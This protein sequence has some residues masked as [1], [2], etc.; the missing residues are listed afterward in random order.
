M[1]VQFDDGKEGTVTFSSNISPENLTAGSETAVQACHHH[2]PDL[3]IRKVL[4]VSFE[5]VSLTPETYGKVCDLIIRLEEEL[6]QFAS[7]DSRAPILKAIESLQEIT[8]EFDIE[9][10]R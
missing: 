9:L 8:Q 2:F 6:K 3:P 5:G 7:D 10:S 1:R 4:A